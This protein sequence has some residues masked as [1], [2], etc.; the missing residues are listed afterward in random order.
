MPLLFGGPICFSSFGLVTWMTKAYLVTGLP[1]NV[2]G[3]MLQIDA[4]RIKRA[5]IMFR[6]VAM[7]GIPIWLTK[8][9]LEL[10]L[11]R[12]LVRD[13]CVET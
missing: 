4:T 8:S 13:I 10:L 9:L 3:N 11:M 1:H 12:K 5:F 2:R 7:K 6:V